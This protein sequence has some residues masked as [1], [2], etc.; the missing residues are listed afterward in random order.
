M[1]SRTLNPGAGMYAKP[2][3]FG[4]PSSRGSE[5]VG[6][7]VGTRRLLAGRMS[8]KIA[9][10]HG[11]SSLATKGFSAAESSPTHTLLKDGQPVHCTSRLVISLQRVFRA[12][13]PRH[14]M[15]IVS[16]WHHIA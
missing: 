15:P 9:S 16:G 6:W 13:S 4:V 2:T 11:V 12:S 7:T 8:V 1:D 5:R 3:S 10:N 14:P